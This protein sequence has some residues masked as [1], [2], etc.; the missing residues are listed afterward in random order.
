MRR[1]MWSYWSPGWAKILSSTHLGFT[2]G[3][4][5]FNSKWSAT[6]TDVIV[7]R[8]SLF[9]L[10]EVEISRNDSERICLIKINEWN[11]NFYWLGYIP[12][13]FH[14]KN[15]T[16]LQRQRRLLNRHQLLSCPK[17]SETTIFEPWI[18]SDF[19]IQHAHCVQP[20]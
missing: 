5:L 19:Y 18:A 10:L 20:C 6:Q 8:L 15:P 3:I 13:N 16:L 17:N 9:T 11:R 14:H 12:G 1:W 4:N 7:L 2:W